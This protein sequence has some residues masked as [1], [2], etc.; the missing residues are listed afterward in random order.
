MGRRE[1]FP[2][3]TSTDCIFGS[4]RCFATLHFNLADQSNSATVGHAKAA[5]PLTQA[6]RDAIVQFEMGLF[7][8]QVFDSNAHYLGAHGSNGGP[9]F[10]AEQGILFRHQRRGCR[11]LQ[12]GK[13]LQSR[14]VP[15]YDVWANLATGRDDDGPPF[16]RARPSRAARPCSTPNRSTSWA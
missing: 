6:Q 3:A 4:T 10:A 7:T 8:A 12:D 1:T 13:A 15:L 11:R 14:R 5:Q 2:D 9:Q 16:R